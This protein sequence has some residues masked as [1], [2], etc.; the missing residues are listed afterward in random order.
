M[1]KVIIVVG[2]LC[3]VAFFYSPPIQNAILYTDWDA[4]SFSSFFSSLGEFLGWV[5]NLTQWS[6]ERNFNEFLCWI[7]DVFSI[8]K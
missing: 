6:A 5:S 3:G 1:K 7:G 8:G 4:S 2:V